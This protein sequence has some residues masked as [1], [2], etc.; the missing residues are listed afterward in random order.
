MNLLLVALLLAG[1][2]VPVTT[3]S[4]ARNADQDI[5]AAVVEAQRAGKRILLEVGGE[6]CSWCH[7]LDR[8][9]DQHP[10]L[11]ASRDRHYIV[12]KINFSPENENKIV[13]SRY[14]EISGCPFLFVL[15]TDGKLLH[16]QPTDP[17]EEGQ[18]YNLQRFTAFLE[19][20][21]PPRK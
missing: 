3:Y 16:A 4:P 2:Y 6:W 5:K 18:S 9:F 14:P 13:L 12:V 21:A 17:L 20:W 7:T 11:T 1:Q 10:A 8:Y 19:K 15:D